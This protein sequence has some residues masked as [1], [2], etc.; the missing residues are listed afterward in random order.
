[1]PQNRLP[2]CIHA[3]FTACFIHY[4]KPRCLTQRLSATGDT[5][6]K[7]PWIIFGVQVEFANRHFH[8]CPWSSSPD[9]SSLLASNEYA[10]QALLDLIPSP[11]KSIAIF[12]LSFS[13]HLT[14]KWGWYCSLV[15]AATCRI[16]AKIHQLFYPM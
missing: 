1:M 2:L 3:K 13:R 16:W 11:L 5:F 12:I 6:S 7:W 10:L 4:F 14:W 9:I 8:Y 15:S